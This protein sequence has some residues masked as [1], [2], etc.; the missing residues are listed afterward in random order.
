[1]LYTVWVAIWKL[2][3]L[4]EITIYHDW[5]SSKPDDY[6]AY[7]YSDTSFGSTCEMLYNFFLEKDI[8]KTIGTCIYRNSNWFRFL[9]FQELLENI[10]IFVDLGV[11]NT[12]IP[13]LL[14]KTVHTVDYSYWVSTTKTWK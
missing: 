10:E 7:T 3:S 11:E 2:F 8:D 6:A 12:K 9:R 4:D 13:T 14:L 5:P 1:M